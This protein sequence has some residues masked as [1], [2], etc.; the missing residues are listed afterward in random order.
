MDRQLRTDRQRRPK[1][2]KKGS[3]TIRWPRSIKNEWTSIDAFFLPLQLPMKKKEVCTRS[4]F[5]MR[6]QTSKTER[7]TLNFYVVRRKFQNN[8]GMRKG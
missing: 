1:S 6:Q 4:R 3:T 7:S 2:T 5:S 8:V